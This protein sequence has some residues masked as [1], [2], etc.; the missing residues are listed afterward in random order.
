[1]ITETVAY[2]APLMPLHQRD[3]EALEAIFQNLDDE[4]LEQIEATLIY[5]V[6]P[7]LDSWEEIGLQM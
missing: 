7:P 2:A 5:Q 6:V 1:M 3:W 4:Q